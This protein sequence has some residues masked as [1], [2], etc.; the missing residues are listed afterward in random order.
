MP[1][2]EFMKSSKI[3]GVK[4]KKI[5]YNKFILRFDDENTR[6]SKEKG[7]VEKQISNCILNIS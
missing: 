4:G 2:T 6:K 7:K 3:C 5:D 1:H